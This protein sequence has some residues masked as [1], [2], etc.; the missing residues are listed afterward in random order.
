M[1]H[2]KFYA[3]WAIILLFMLPVCNLSASDQLI[4]GFLPYHSPSKLIGL[5]KPLI[6]FLNEDLIETVTMISAP[7]FKAFRKRTR[8]GHYDLIFTAPHM[9]RLAEIEVGY[10][11]V[12]M[13][14]HMGRPMFLTLTASGINNLLDLTRTS[15]N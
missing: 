15:R 14:T 11:R 9:A 1:K 4:F 12:V 5:H 6:K 7:N 2:I 10:K 8:D 13:S 3:V